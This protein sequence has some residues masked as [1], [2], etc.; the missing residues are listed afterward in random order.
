MDLPTPYPGCGE[1]VSGS[2]ERVMDIHERG[3][4]E[5]RYVRGGTASQAST[6]QPA[7]ARAKAGAVPENLDDPGPC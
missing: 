1:E 2:A 4:A 3:W 7:V 5:R 6:Q